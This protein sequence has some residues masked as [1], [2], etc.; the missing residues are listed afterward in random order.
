MSNTQ[1]T[2]LTSKLAAKFDLGDGS[3]LLDTLKKTA[4]KGA[5]SDEQM[6][7]LLIV[8]KHIRISEAGCWECQRNYKRDQR[9]AKQRN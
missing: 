4:F 7:A 2:T 5:V 9:A 1:L 8:A 3:G 6:T